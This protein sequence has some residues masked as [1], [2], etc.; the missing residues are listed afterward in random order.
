MQNQFIA[1]AVVAVVLGMDAFSLSLGMGL[2]GVK[3]KYEIKFSA[4]VGILHI[5]MPLVGLNLGIAAGRLFGVWAA[6]AGAIV[7]AYIGIDFL[8][9]GIREVKTT[10]ISFQNAR[11]ILNPVQNIVA[12]DW[13]AIM[14]LAASVSIDALTVGFGLGTL[15]MPIL[16]TV[17]TIGVIAALMTMLGFIAG[18]ACSKIV[19]SYAQILGGILLL[20]LAVKLVSEKFLM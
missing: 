1:I 7:L 13:K 10:S 18:R 14:L 20:A 11:K 8:V 12:D 2:R 3:L 15:R 5:I 17:I 16:V 6:V 4:A 9:K 19:G